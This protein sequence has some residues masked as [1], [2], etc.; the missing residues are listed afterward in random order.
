MSH[1]VENE[2]KVVTD[3]EHEEPDHIKEHNPVI[4]DR[5]LH[6]LFDNKYSSRKRSLLPVGSDLEQHSS[7]PN[8][9]RKATKSQD[10]T[11]A[12]EGA[13]P[14]VLQSQPLAGLKSVVK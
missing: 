10:L 3:L 7:Q 9:D 8:E 5:E 6:P 13:K 12:L 11:P 1:Y 2:D 4:S 14:P